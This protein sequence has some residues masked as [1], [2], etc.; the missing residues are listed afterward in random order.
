[1]NSLGLLDGEHSEVKDP[2]QEQI[3]RPSFPKLNLNSYFTV[4]RQNEEIHDLLVGAITIGMMNETA[5]T[6]CSDLVS[7]VIDDSISGKANAILNAEDLD[8]VRQ[9][10]IPMIDASPEDRQPNG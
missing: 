10:V 7:K 9:V 3:F 8:L 6:S 2:L 1:M 4:L 5:I